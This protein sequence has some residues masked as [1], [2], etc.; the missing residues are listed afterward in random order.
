MG[1]GDPTGY[2]NGHGHDESPLNTYKI[3]TR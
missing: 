1:G 3:I 2:G